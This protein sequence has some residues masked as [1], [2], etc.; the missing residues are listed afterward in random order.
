MHA[1]VAPITEE[2][3]RRGDESGVEVLGEG[4][5]GVVGKYA[6]EHDGVVLHI[7]ALKVFFGKE[8]ADAVCGF[9]GGVWRRLGGFD[10]DRKVE[11]FFTLVE[12]SA[13]VVTDLPDG[14]IHL[15]VGAAGLAEKSL[16]ME[17]V[18]LTS[19]RPLKE[20]YDAPGDTG[21]W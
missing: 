19:P 17:S 12:I 14:N 21:F 15:I 10:D 5:A 7:G 18:L 9:P 16:S 8:F 3:L 13:G 4:L 2:F 6:D 1:H 20:T 11:D